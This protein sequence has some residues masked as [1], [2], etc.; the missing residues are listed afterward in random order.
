MSPK[1]ER[2]AILNREIADKVRSGDYFK[3]AWDWYALKYILPVSQRTFFIFVT[4]LSLAVTFFSI[5]VFTSFLPIVTKVPI[6]VGNPAMSDYY[7]HLYP[8]PVAEDTDPNLPV[9]E[10]LTRNYVTR[11]EEYTYDSIENRKNYLLNFSDA[12]LKSEIEKRYDIRNLNSPVLKFRDHTTRSIRITSYSLEKSEAFAVENNDDKDML[13]VNIPYRAVLEF[14]SEEK[15]VLGTTTK[16]WMAEVKFTMS[17]V[18]FDK[19]KNAFRPLDFHVTSYR[20]SP[21]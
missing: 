5:Q 6:V 21:I 12:A 2:E 13:A 7:A 3:E 11:W 10:Y 15:N 20:T 9:I 1:P 14:E 19:E 8:L 18:Y 16:K 4:L 17:P